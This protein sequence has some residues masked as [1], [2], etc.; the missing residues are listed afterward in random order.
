MIILILIIQS[1][2]PIIEAE[3][4]HGRAEVAVCDLVINRATGSF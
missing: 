2:L 1:S 4:Q 3:W